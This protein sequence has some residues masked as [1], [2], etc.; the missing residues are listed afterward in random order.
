MK[1]LFKI[2]Y[3]GLAFIMAIFI[4]M[5]GY[6]S[7]GYTYIQTLTREAINDKNYSEVAKIHGGCFYSESI[8]TDNSDKFDLAVFPSATLS[9]YTYYSSNELDATSQTEHVYENSYYIYIITPTY[10]FN[11]LTAGEKFNNTAIKFNSESGSYT[12]LLNVTEFINTDSMA[13]QPLSVNDVALKSARNAISNYNSWGFFNVTLTDTMIKAMQTELNGNITSITI[14]DSLG[15]DVDTVEV[16][17]SFNH[18][19][20]I[21][22]QPLSTEYNKFIKDYNAADQAGNKDGLKEAENKFNAFYEGDENTKGFKETFFELNDKNSFRHDDDYLRPGK[23]VWQSIGMII[24]FVVC[25]TLLYILI[26]H[27]KFIKSI[28][29]KDRSGNYKKGYGAYKKSNTINAKAETV[30]PVNK[31]SKPAP[32]KEEKPKAIEEKIAEPENKEPIE[33]EIV[34]AEVVDTVTEEKE[35]VE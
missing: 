17:L 6:N 12:Y 29:F 7:N 4:Y 21:D 16:D 33:A 25:A 28:V 8:V 2:L 10:E 15:K 27:F 26:F 1:S 20:F 24:L 5:L 34:E 35:N 11:D 19:F 18:Q 3:V 23:L 9:S 13:A 31:A 30:K 32:V 22:I 14:V